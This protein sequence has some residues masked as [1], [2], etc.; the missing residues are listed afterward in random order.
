MAADEEEEEEEEEDTETP[1]P[2][3]IASIHK[4]KQE[5]AMQENL[6]GGVGN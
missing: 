1:V 6:V 2:P 3:T 4:K 5:M